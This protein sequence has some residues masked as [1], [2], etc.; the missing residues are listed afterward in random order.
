[1][2]EGDGLLNRCRTLKFYRGFESLRL[3]FSF[4]DFQRFTNVIFKNLKDLKLFFA[5]L[6]FVK[7]KKSQFLEPPSPKFEPHKSSSG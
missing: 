2:A 7:A 1:M 5:K 4:V 6:E 3:R